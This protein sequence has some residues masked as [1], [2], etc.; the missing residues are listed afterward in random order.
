VIVQS[1]FVDR[2]WATGAV[3]AILAEGAGATR[4]STTGAVIGIETACALAPKI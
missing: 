4:D 2:D 1:P 3:I